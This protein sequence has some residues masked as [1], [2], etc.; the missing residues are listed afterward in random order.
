MVALRQS[1]VTEFVMRNQQCADCA[2]QYTPHTWK[3]LVQIRLG[4]TGPRRLEAS[5]RILAHLEDLL[6]GGR[7]SKR[8]GAWS[9]TSKNG[10]AK[11]GA[12]SKNGSNSGGGGERAS[13]QIATVQQ[14]LSDL[15]K[16]HFSENGSTGADFYF[17]H[18][19]QAFLSL[20]KK[21]FV[22][23]KT[24]STKT[25]VS[26][27]AK[28]NKHR[29]K[30]TILLELAPIVK[31]DL[32]SIVDFRQLTK[33]AT[34]IKNVEFLKNCGLLLCVGAGRGRLD[35]VEPV[36]GRGFVLHDWK[37][38]RP[39]ADRSMLVQFCCLDVEEE[40]CRGS[41]GVLGGG[42]S[43]SD[44][45]GTGSDRGAGSGASGS[46]GE[47]ASGDAELSTSAKSSSESDGKKRS[48][49]RKNRGASGRNVSE[50][51]DHHEKPINKQNSA[52]SSASMSS[53]GRVA[54]DAVAATPSVG[55][56]VGGPP[57]SASSCGED[58][59][60]DDPDDEDDDPEEE[61]LKNMILRATSSATT[62]SDSDGEEEDPLADSCEG[63]GDLGADADAAPPGGLHQEQAQE[64]IHK[65]QPENANAVN[66][67]PPTKRVSTSSFRPHIARRRL[68]VAKVSDLGA[69]EDGNMVHGILLP[70][71]NKTKVDVSDLVWGYDLRVLVR[72]ELEDLL[73]RGARYPDVVLCH[74]VRGSTTT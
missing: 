3:F 6:A 14:I 67:R 8:G 74:R 26:H 43:G 68:D 60:D 57:A 59:P 18:L 58:V 69:T 20:V 38:L 62:D 46:E 48:S 56:A 39:I 11:S 16:S 23:T 70:L 19:P 10:G 51:E 49:R 9:S 66:H 50:R 54:P 40:P 37:G 7:S 2:R 41:G 22:V 61:Q 24:K 64:P 42:G 36:S 65:D 53:D 5:R 34:R 35:F 4:G 13:V 17:L 72:Q 55:A 21:E 31:Y 28:S 71:G 25:L 45:G 12:G 29:H 1:H 47:S 15:V 32:C 52:A 63:E 27:D 44:R 33:H 73:D 30:F